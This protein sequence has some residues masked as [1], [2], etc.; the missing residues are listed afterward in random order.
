MLYKN[1]K[2]LSYSNFYEFHGQLCNLR[3]RQCIQKEVTS[4][5]H[6]K[7]N[8]YRKLKATLCFEPLGCA[9]LNTQDALF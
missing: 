3:N 1:P 7:T 6:I 2:I 9:L 5:E 8:V 4:E